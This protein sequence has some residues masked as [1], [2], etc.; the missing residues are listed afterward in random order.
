MFLNSTYFEGELY[1]P[2]LERNYSEGVGISRITQTVNENS[3]EWYIEKYEPEYLKKLLGEHLYFAFIT[4]IVKEEHDP[5]WDVLLNMIY[6]KKDKYSFSPAA[7]Y[8]YFNL[9]RSSKS[10]I[11]GKGEKLSN[12][13]DSLNVD[14]VDKLTGIWNDMCDMSDEIQN[15]IC[16]SD[17][18]YP[19][20]PHWKESFKC[21]SHHMRIKHFCFHR[22][23]KINSFNI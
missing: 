5:K 7:N 1:L 17:L 3:L 19:H 22:F 13:F 16:R 4:E 20:L 14:N 9:G 11:T 23:K 18:Y 6:R 2:S 15:F 12:V 21:H 10:Q 8:V